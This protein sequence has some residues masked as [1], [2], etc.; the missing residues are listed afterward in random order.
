[1]RKRNEL[2]EPDDLLVSV[3]P[4]CGESIEQSADECPSCGCNLG[5][6]PA[7][8]P[9]EAETPPKNNRRAWAVTGTAAIV[10]LI[11]TAALFGFRV[12][13]PSTMTQPSIVDFADTSSNT[14]HDISANAAANAT[15]VDAVD[16]NA[17]DMNATDLLDTTDGQFASTSAAPDPGMAAKIDDWS[18]EADPDYG[19]EGAIKW[20]VSVRN[21]SSRPITSA[22]VDFSAYDAD[23]HLLTTTF[24]YVDNI[25]PGETRDEES[26]ADYHGGEQTARVAVTYL[27]FGD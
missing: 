26:F 11:A 15:E 7:E 4:G 27:R 24:T 22:K 20:R 10:L 9:A 2:A 5:E 18:W 12:H 6:I 14:D 8:P 13:R 23:H 25:P 1:L 16:M 3:C 19:T 21:L 17:T